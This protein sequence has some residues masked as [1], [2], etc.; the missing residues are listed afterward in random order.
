MH[1]HPKALVQIALG[2]IFKF[3]VVQYVLRVGDGI[4]KSLS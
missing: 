2:R 4:L 1:E 3:V